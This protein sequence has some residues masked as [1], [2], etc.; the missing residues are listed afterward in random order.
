M[1]RLKFMENITCGHYDV[2]TVQTKDLRPGD[3]IEQDSLIFEVLSVSSRISP[4]K[5]HCVLFSRW[6]MRAIE[7]F[8]FTYLEEMEQFTSMYHGVIRWTDDT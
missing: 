1:N 8:K 5:Q 2:F 3:I 4:I 6:E 7:D